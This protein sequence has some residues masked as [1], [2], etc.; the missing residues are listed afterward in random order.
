[1]AEAKL[2]NFGGQLDWTA[3]FVKLSTVRVASLSSKD[4]NLNKVLINSSFIMQY[5]IQTIVCF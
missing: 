5:L 3:L 2:R 4:V 1:M